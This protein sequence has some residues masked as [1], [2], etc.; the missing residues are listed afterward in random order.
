MDGFISLLGL[1]LGV[2]AVVLSFR[3]AWAGLR[4]AHLQ[5]FY[6]ISPI[7]G[8]AVVLVLS[9]LA[10]LGFFFG[11]LIVLEQASKG[12]FPPRVAYVLA[13][14]MTLCGIGSFVLSRRARAA[15]EGRVLLDL[16]ILESIGG[17][18]G[19]AGLAIGAALAANHY[20]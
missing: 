9:M 18:L 20:Q 17:R 8:G 13:F 10:N 12:I 16:A 7:F 5:G 14:V 11:I 2:A 6:V 15:R 1:V 19:I 3:A 4:F